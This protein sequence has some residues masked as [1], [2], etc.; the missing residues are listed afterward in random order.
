MVRKWLKNRMS[1]ANAVV[2]F[3]AT[4]GSSRTLTAGQTTEG[5]EPWRETSLSSTGALVQ[6]SALWVI[7]LQAHQMAWG[8]LWAGA[9]VR[10][11]AGRPDER[12]MRSL[13]VCG[14]EGLDQGGG[15]R[16][17]LETKGCASWLFQAPAP[18]DVSLGTTCHL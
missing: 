3:A 8:C 14:D 4:V 18:A 9:E 17:K 5:L 13:Q 6:R 11:E 12:P 10:L 15:H 16:I 1:E 7:P 2:L